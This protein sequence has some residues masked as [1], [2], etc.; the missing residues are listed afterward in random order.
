MELSVPSRL[1]GGKG[2][3]DGGTDRWN[4]GRGFLF[5]RGCS[6]ANKVARLPIYVFFISLSRVS[7]V[8]LQTVYSGEQTVQ[9]FFTIKTFRGHMQAELCVRTVKT[10]SLKHGFLLKK[11]KENKSVNN[12]VLL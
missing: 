9:L 4:A 6:R 8:I 1:T 10:D 7:H 3:T 11:K 5:G 2:L 12:V